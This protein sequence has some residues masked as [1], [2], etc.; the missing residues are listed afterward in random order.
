LAPDGAEI[1]LSIPVTLSRLPLA[2]GAPPALHALAARKIIQDLEDGQH[3][4]ADSGD[5]DLLE[6][7]VRAHIVRLGTTYQI[8]STHTSFVAVD[9]SQ[10]RRPRYAQLVAEL[11]PSLESMDA[12]SDIYEASVLH[13]ELDGGAIQYARQ[14]RAQV[15]PATSQPRLYAGSAPRFYATPQS[16]PIRDTSFLSRLLDRVSLAFSYL[17]LPTLPLSSP[18]YSPP[19]TLDTLEALARLQTF[20]GAFPSPSAVLALVPLKAGTTLTDVRRA[21][22]VGAADELVGSVLALSFV[23]VKMKMEAGTEGDAWEGVY[24]KAREWVEAALRDLGAAETATELEEKVG[25]MLAIA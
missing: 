7:T 16:I 11:E 18:P 12:E 17:S 24:E 10:A 1:A 23:G 3:G 2:P 15:R 13:D 21:L 8:A 9:E 4:L 19:E 14:Y 5:A 20:D 6:R 25:G 22:P